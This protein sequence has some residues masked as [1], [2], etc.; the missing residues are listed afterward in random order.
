[1]TFSFYFNLLL[2]FLAKQL[3]IVEVNYPT[4]FNLIT[5]TYKFWLEYVGAQNCVNFIVFILVWDT[6]SFDVYHMDVST[7]IWLLSGICLLYNF[8]INYLNTN[9]K[10]EYPTLHKFVS[11][12]STL[13]LIYNI[14]HI[15]HNIVKIM[16][17]PGG[18]PNGGGSFNNGGPSP[19][20]GPDG[21]PLTIHSRPQRR[22]HVSCQWTDQYNGVNPVLERAIDRE[23]VLLEGYDAHILA[24]TDRYNSYYDKYVNGTL[25]KGENHF[26]GTYAE[27]IKKLLVKRQ[28]CITDFENLRNSINNSNIT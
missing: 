21:N 15:L 2:R 4:I 14:I 19:N 16:G 5:K 28:S 1:M 23:K 11:I 18:L 24:Q 7:Y 8:Y 22:I 10:D 6:S 17:G 26:I 25:T 13:L 3:N 27:Q 12:L 20:M 9:F